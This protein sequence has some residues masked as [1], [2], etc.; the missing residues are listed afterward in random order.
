MEIS[1]AAMGL[2]LTIIILMIMFFDLF[3]KKWDVLSWRNIFLLGYLHFFGVGAYLTATSNNFSDR[4]ISSPKS[5]SILAIALIVFLVVFMLSAKLGARMRFLG[6]LVP[7]VELPITSTGM[8]IPIV[9]LVI[10][11]LLSSL[12][13]PQNF[14]GLLAVQFKAGMV[15]TAMGLAAFYLMANRFNPFSWLVFLTTFGAA[16]LVSVTGG[17]SRRGVLGIL[18]ILP[19]FWYYMILRYR[20]VSMTVLKMGVPA[21][22]ALLFLLAYT[23][24]RHESR[25]SNFDAGS[26]IEEFKEMVTN[27]Q[28]NHNSFD[29]MLYTDT[30]NNT[31][32]IIE[33]YTTSAD[34]IPFHGLKFFLLNPVP[35]IFWHDKPEALG[36]IL[37]DQMDTLANLGPGI[38]GHGWAEGAWIGV[39]VY[40]IFFGILVGV[41]DQAIRERCWNPFF[42]ALTGCYLGNVM[43]MPRGDTPLFLLQLTAGMVSS[44]IVL[45]G[46][47]LVFKSVMLAGKPLTINAALQH[48][49]EYEYQYDDDNEWYGP[50]EDEQPSAAT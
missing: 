7:K 46:L 3:R 39:L 25:D 44:T 6:R 14:I 50:C 8:I 41:I 1:L 49:Y 47:R 35:R 11:G 2:I 28:I 16:V 34:F 43:A 22:A 18:I 4:F 12:V 9:I 36:I 32:F 30:T 24:V 45:Y 23:G 17:S 13:P 33:N 15:G 5:M 27:P 31:L 42:L 29:I 19:W 48:E 10:L 40:A 38:I 20:S 21:V 37:Q 26:R